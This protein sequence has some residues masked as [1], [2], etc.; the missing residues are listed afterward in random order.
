MQNPSTIKAFLEDSDRL[1]SSG[2]ELLELDGSPALIKANEDFTWIQCFFDF[3]TKLAR[4]RGF[5]R[6]MQD[7]NGSWKAKYVIVFISLY[8]VYL[9]ILRTFYVGTE[10]LKG[11]E[12][13]FGKV[14]ISQLSRVTDTKRACRL[15]L[16]VL[17]T[18]NM[19]NVRVGRTDVPRSESS[20]TLSLRFSLSELA[21]VA[22]PLV[23][24]SASSMLMP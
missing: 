22:C 16:L 10:E 13:K 9:T 15:D 24:V 4:G 2:L 21:K 18:V 20:L 7:D 1:K 5:F 23:P 12:E 19:L 14:E 8:N 6:L 3:E 11:F 17:T